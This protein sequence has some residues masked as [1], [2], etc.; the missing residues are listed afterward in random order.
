MY[1]PE[2]V[3]MFVT[4]VHLTV[5]GAFLVTA[6]P[7]DDVLQFSGRDTGIVMP[8]ASAPPSA[9]TVGDGAH[10]PGHL[11]CGVSGAHS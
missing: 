8:P 7:S 3:R 5:F 6:S 10:R 2:P 1:L 9:G 4:R 11:L